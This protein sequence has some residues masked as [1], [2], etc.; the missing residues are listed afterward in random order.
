MDRWNHLNSSSPQL[1]YLSS[2]CSLNKTQKLTHGSCT[3]ISLPREL[4][5]NCR[6][7]LQMGPYNPKNSPTL[8]LSFSILNQLL[9]F[10]VVIMRTNTTTC[11]LLLSCGF[12][13]SLSESTKELVTSHLLCRHLILNTLLPA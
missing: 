7:C 11:V 8:P 12:Y 9:H 10:L 5:H 4:S 13:S 1:S 2:C 3:Q 6:I